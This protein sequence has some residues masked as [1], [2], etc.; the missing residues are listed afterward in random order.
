NYSLTLWWMAEHVGIDRNELADEEVKKAAKGQSFNSNLL[1]SVLCQK[2]K[3]SIAALKQDH[4][5]HT[6][7]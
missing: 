6:K 2:L 4:N 3:I 5:K 1:P 7:A